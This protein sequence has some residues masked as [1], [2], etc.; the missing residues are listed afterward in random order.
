MFMPENENKTDS[1][2]K[3]MKDNKVVA[4]LIISSIALTAVLTIW[5]SLLDLR[6]KL[7]PYENEVSA[8]VDSLKFE[9]KEN[10]QFL[11]NEN[12]SHNNSNVKSESYKE[13]PKEYDLYMELNVLVNSAYSESIILID[14]HPAN[15]T[16]NNW[17]TKK[18]K[19][20]MDHLVHELKL[21]TTTDTCLITFYADKSEKD[22]IACPYN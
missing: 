22:L 21:I 3:R 1:L 8:E 6:Q 5:N 10:H 11:S 17:L 15:I 9:S 18:I 13:A 20:K 16:R 19:T 7:V 4:I 12:N 14:N 2:I